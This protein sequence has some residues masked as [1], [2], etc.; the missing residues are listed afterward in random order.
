MLNLST[1]LD[2]ASHL[3]L[4]AVGVI[5]IFAAHTRVYVYKQDAIARESLFYSHTIN[6]YF[7]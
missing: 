5:A 7:H 4:R 2:Y 3:L 6:Y 1:T